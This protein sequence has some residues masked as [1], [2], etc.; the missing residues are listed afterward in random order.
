MTALTDTLP[1]GSALSQLLPREARL[2]RCAIDLNGTDAATRFPGIELDDSLRESVPKRQLQYLA[3][4][5]CAL[6]ALRAFGV[7]AARLPRQSNRLPDWPKGFTGS[8]S[9]SGDEA[10]AVVMRKHDAASVGLDVESI[11]SADRASRVAPLVAGSRELT[12]AYA[13]GLDTAAAVTLVFSAK[14]ALFK[15][16]FPFAQRWLGYGAAE[17]ETRQDGTFSVRLAEPWSEGF[18]AG[19]TFTGRWAQLDGRIYTALWVRD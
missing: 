9:H 12:A 5:F 15:C 3:G 14:E 13:A 18:G 19:A 8:I 11:V 6:E 2:R 4:R 1:A 7:D 16:L 17:I 10:C